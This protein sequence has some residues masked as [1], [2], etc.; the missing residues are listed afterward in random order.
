[1]SKKP[2]RRDILK[3]LGA[4]A[5]VASSPMELFLDQLVPSLIE[6]ASA[7]ETEALANK[8]ILVQQFGAPPRWMYDLF[9]SPYGNNP[10]ANIMANGSVASELTGG[11]RYTGAAYKT[12]KVKGINA[13]VIWKSNV[14]DGSGAPRPISDLMDNMLVLQGIDALNPGHAPAAALM[15]RPLTQYSIDGILADQAG[16]PFG[17]IGLGSTSL[18]FKS[19]KGKN[20]KLYSGGQDMA[21]LLPEAF[22]AGVGNLH[23][24]YSKEIDGAVEK[25]NR[26]IA[27]VKLGSGSL[28]LDQAGARK[29]MEGEVAKIAAA[30]PVL[31]AKYE[32]IIS[33]TVKMSQ[34]L[35]GLS[36]K[37]VGKTGDRTGDLNYRESSGDRI[38]TDADM[39]DTI[40]TANI[41]NL[42]KEFAV[43][44]Y[45]ITNNLTS[46][47]SIGVGSLRVNFN[48]A[49][50]TVT[51]DQHRTGV[52]NSV[53]Y[54][55]LFYRINSACIL[56]LIE[57]LKTTAYKGSNMFDH[58]VIRQSNEFG[59][60]PRTDGTGSDHSPWSSNCMLLS[61]MIKG[62]IIAGQIL[63]DGASIGRRPG[64]WGAAGNLKHGPTATT[65]H[66]ISSIAT[67]LGVE[68][69]SVNNP[70]LVVKNDKGEVE[71][72]SG[73]IDKTEVV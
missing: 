27:G 50:R 37:P 33:E 9:L 38:V 44:E 24:E 26:G 21:A 66:V 22:A 54:T 58:T 8:Y 1:M 32:K 14:A 56:G 55:T 25:L 29:L 68:T 41:P 61:G 43:A 71:L 60:Y 48:G 5:A 11:A 6:R 42:A 51:K 65:G 69:P 10:M 31:L 20:A 23:K 67:M 15:N 57:G 49:A 40:K 64:S 39:R 62:P 72:N 45:V 36:D 35:E 12:H 52:L 18:D 4:G 73:Y 17:G 16:L 7:T 46:S 70:S 28:S 13:P 47:V 53:F 59:R 30:Y 19:P 63:K 2:S 3:L 34:G